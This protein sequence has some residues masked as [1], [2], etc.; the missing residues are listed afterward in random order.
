MADEIVELAFVAADHRDMRAEPCKQPRDRPPDAAGASRHHHDQILERIGR[1]HRRMDRKLVVSQAVLR[2][3]SRRLMIIHE[4][5]VLERFAGKP[6]ICRL[7]A[8]LLPRSA[9]TV[10]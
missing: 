9:A 7:G 1:K 3:R 5:P 6:A 10:H 4:R 8:D 2:R